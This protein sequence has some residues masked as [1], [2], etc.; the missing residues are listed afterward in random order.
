MSNLYKIFSKLILGRITKTLE[1]N[2]PREQAGFRK[3]FSTIDHILVIKQIT[4]KCQEYQMNYYIAFVDYNKAFDSLKHTEIWKTLNEQGISQ[5]YIRIIQEIYSNSTAKIKLERLGEEF[6]IRKG[7][8][9]GDP[10]SPK[11][12]IAV[13]ESVFRRM[14][15]ENYGLNILGRKLN[16]LRFA[17]DLILVS[18]NPTDLKIMLEELDTQSKLVGLSMN[19]SKTKLMSNSAKAPIDVNGNEIEYMNEYVY[20]GQ[21]ISPEDQTDKELQ[22]RTTNAWKKFWSLKDVLKAK[23][24]PTGQ[25]FKIFKSCIIPVLSYGCQTWGLTKKQEQ[26]LNVCQNNME[27]TILN[28]KLRDR[29]KIT[30]IKA[31]SKTKT[32]SSV[33]KQQKW[34]WAGHI[35]RENKDKWTRELVEWCPRYNTR[36]SGPQ[37]YRWSNDLRKTGGKAWMSVA[38][39]R[40]EWKTLEEA[41][42]KGRVGVA[43]GNDK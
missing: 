27:R 41:F 35:M 12:F 36:K 26:K 21:V 34:R 9:Q 1:E 16:H 5:K 19:M 7:V 17:D 43:D 33:I 25:K 38:R 42:V 4:E 8:R 30:T 3:N 28:I 20:L 37:Q 15:W 6:P 11:I 39:N 22:R 18:D 32:L 40:P 24:I 31:K 10:L 29:V 14:N 23:E 13:L 2:Q